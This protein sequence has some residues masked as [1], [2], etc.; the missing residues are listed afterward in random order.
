MERAC[1]VQETFPVQEMVTNPLPQGQSFEI[2][3][4][5]RKSGVSP[6]DCPTRAA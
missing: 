5:E 6:E 2:W 3:Q 1:E 4:A